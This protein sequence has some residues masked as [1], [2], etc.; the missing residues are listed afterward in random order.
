MKIFRLFFRWSALA[1]VVA[2]A[3]GP[4]AWILVTALK[5]SED[6]FA[7]P[8]SLLP[9]D[10]GIRN[11][12]EVFAIVPFGT[13]LLNSILVSLASVV[14]N[15]LLASLAAYPLAR[16]DFRGRQ[17]VFLLILAT[18]MVPEQVTMIPVFRLLLQMGLLDTLAGVVLPTCVS[19]FGVFL[20]RQHYRSIPRELDEAAV[21]D[22]CSV[23]GIWW[24]IL[25]PLS[26]PALATLAVFTFVGSWSS[27]LWPLVVLQDPARYTLPVG[28]NALLSAFSANYKY[29]A[30]GAVLTLI[31]VV[32]VLLF[33]QRYLVKGMLAGGVKG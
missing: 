16:M 11:F 23:L 7:F 18:M 4:F 13:Y 33:F 3:A 1:W 6:V 8:P 32:A 2:I 27:F 30:A 26:T 29:L 15:L 21:M 5:G 31:P 25:V 12:V 28:L 10:P 20:M 22:G 9:H 17:W 24:R 19:A 14:L